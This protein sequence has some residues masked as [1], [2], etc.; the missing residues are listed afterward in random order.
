V[1]DNFLSK[2]T[3]PSNKVT[4]NTTTFG[5]RITTGCVTQIDNLISSSGRRRRDEL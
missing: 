2:R 4:A 3:A 1:D 5:T